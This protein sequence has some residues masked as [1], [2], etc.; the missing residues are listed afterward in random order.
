MPEY[1]VDVHPDDSDSD[2]SA[3]SLDSE[4]GVPIMWTPGVKKALT[5]RA[6]TEVSHYAYNEY[7]AHH[8]A[9]AMKVA[10]EQEPE[11]P[12]LRH[13]L[14]GENRLNRANC[15]KEG[16]EPHKLRRAVQ[17][18]ASRTT[19]QSHE[20]SQTGCWTPHT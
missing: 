10:V 1:E 5:S 14:E 12:S 11:R 19:T 13:K 8:Y 4:F 20:E 18:R 3:P 2:V 6:K 17:R 15:G 16:R 9:F 7:M